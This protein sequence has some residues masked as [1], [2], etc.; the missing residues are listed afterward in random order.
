MLAFTAAAAFWDPAPSAPPCPG[1]LVDGECWRLSSPS[2]SCADLCGGATRV[3][4]ET[5][6]GDS[7]SEEVVYAIEATYGLHDTSK[8]SLNAPCGW[9]PP[10]TT[11]GP[12]FPEWGMYVF[13]P[14]AYV[15]GGGRWHCI[16]G[17]TYRA[18]SFGVRSPCVCARDFVRFQVSDQKY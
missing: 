17:Q 2:Q 13:V 14:D 9:P 16:E 6:V 12:L 1:A 15:H 10:W 18:V 3:D 7:T 11:G 5:T 8:D 4:A